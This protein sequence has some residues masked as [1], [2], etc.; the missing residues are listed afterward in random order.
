MLILGLLL[1]FVPEPSLQQQCR[2]HNGNVVGVG[3]AECVLLSPYYHRYQWATCLTE[4]YVMRA[5]NQRHYCRGRATVCWYQCMLELHELD[6][7]PVYNDCRCSPSETTT[8]A[9]TDNLH[10]HCYSPRGEDCSWYRECL[11]RRYQCQ[12]TDDG[13]AIEYAE[14]FCNLFADSY[15]DFSNDGRAWIDGVRKCLQV[16]LVPSLRPWVRKTCGD[17]R[18]DAFNSHPECYVNPAS[19]APGICELWCIDVWKTFWLVFDGDALSDAPFET[20]KQ[21]LSVMGRCSFDSGP[22]SG[23]IPTAQTS[24]LITVLPGSIGTRLSVLAAAKLVNY[25]AIEQN[26]VENGFRW[27]PF[28][29]DDDNSE[30]MGNRKRRQSVITDVYTN[31]N[32]LLVDTKALNISNGTTS[33]PTQDQIDLDEAVENLANAVSNGLLSEIPLVVN[34]TQMSL[35]VFSVGQCTDILC[36]STNVTELAIAPSLSPT[37]SSTDATKITELAHKTPPTSGAKTT[38][39]LQLH[40]VS[41]ICAIHLILWKSGG[42]EDYM[43]FSN[44]M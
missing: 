23:C 8:E 28:L 29:D 5:S 36:N 30:F 38:M 32:V 43:Y 24:L 21:M 39:F 2:T 27:F 44:T 22:L 33:T 37:S 1:Y 18:S 17:I 41:V 13:Y 42:S 10:P 34:G 7:G 20:G 31:I 25:I 6:Q 3:E 11:E 26:W 12:G 40:Y 16:A 4:D 14:K 19:G 9:P 35:E 15:N